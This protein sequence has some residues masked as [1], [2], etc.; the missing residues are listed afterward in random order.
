MNERSILV[1]ASELTVIYDSLDEFK[2]STG[3]I[4][5]QFYVFQIPSILH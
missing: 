4:Q 3:N 1:T 2:P 5:D